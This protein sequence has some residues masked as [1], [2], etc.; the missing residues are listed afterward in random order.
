MKMTQDWDQT[1]LLKS[2]PFVVRVSVFHKKEEV[3]LRRPPD[4]GLI[5]LLGMFLNK[6]L[7]VKYQKMGTVSRFARSGI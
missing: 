2:I 3:G 6:V 1:V 4:I 5:R 7:W